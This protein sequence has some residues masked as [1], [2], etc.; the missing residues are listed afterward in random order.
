MYRKRVG[1][2][3]SKITKDIPRAAQKLCGRF[4]RPTHTV[5]LVTPGLTVM[6]ISV[7]VFM[8]AGLL[9]PQIVL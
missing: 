6:W 8:W 4:G 2:I 3:R 5:E 9:V 7:V 1:T